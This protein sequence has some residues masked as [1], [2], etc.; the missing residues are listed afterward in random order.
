MPQVQILYWRQIPAQVRVF[1]DR[2]PLS[3]ALPERF[4]QQI[5]RVAMRE[6]LAGTDE[7]LAQWEWSQKQECEGEPE[8][9]LRDTIAA[10]ITAHDDE[11]KD[12]AA[13]V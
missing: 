11:M 2:R 3:D 12:D 7:Y 13:D 5:D 8:Q 6:G 1:T 4:Q 10:L 9:I